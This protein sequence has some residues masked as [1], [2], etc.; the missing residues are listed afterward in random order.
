MAEI[1]NDTFTADTLVLAHRGLWGKYSGDTALPEN[2]SRA[3]LTA[4]VQRM[5]GVELD[6][7]ITQDAC[8]Y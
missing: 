7:K 5:D 1:L 3:V 6:V 4:D 2:S 8:R